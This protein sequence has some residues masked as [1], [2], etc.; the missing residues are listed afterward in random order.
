[1]LGSGLKQVCLLADYE[2]EL[3]HPMLDRLL[4]RGN[5]SRDY[6]YYGT[7]SE[8]GLLANI[9]SKG[10]KVIVPL[11]ERALQQTLGE[12]GI[13]RWRGRV[14]AHPHLPNVWVMPALQ[15]SKLMSRR[16]GDD[17][18]DALRHPPRYHGVWMR[19]L[20]KVLHI[21][22]NGFSRMP[23]NYLLDPPAERFAQFADE[24]ELALA[25]DPDLFLSWDIETP[26]KQK[27]SDEEELEEK[28]NILDGVILR[29]SFCFKPGYA[30]S[31]P[32]SPTYLPTILRLLRSRG[33][34]VVWNGSTFD[35]P[36]VQSAGYECLGL[37]F[38]F[39]DG[40]H[41]LESDLPKGLEWV[42]SEAT[43][44]LPW[45]HLAS[46]EPAHYS[47]VDADAALRN[48]LYIKAKLIE[49]GQWELFRNHVVR[50][51]PLLAAAGK[52]GNLMDLVKR[53]EIRTELTAMKLELIKEAQTYVPKQLRPRS[54]FKTQPDD[55]T[56]DFPIYPAWTEGFSVAPVLTPMG[57]RWDV[58]YDLDAGKFC[59]HCGRSVGNFAEHLKGGKK[60]N[61]CK[62][63]DAKAEKRPAYVPRFDYIEDFNPNSSPQMMSY[64]THFGHPIG[65]DKRTGKE[66]ADASH[67]KFLVKKF[68]KKFPIYALSLQLHKAIKTIG[69]YTPEPDPEGFLHTQY[70]NSTSTWRFGARK[71]KYGTQ[72]QNWGKRD[73][74]KYA[75]AARKQIIA[76]PGHKLVQ[77]DS[78]AVEAVMQ[79]YF[80]ND[81]LY[82]S[83]ASKSI[84]AWL[85]CRALGW[86]F[87]PDN[88]EKVKAEHEGLYLKMKVTNYLTNFGGGDYLL[89]QTFPENFP[90]R[91]DAV[92]A[93]DSLYALLPTLKAYHH[94][95]RWEA[96]TKTFLTTP[97]GYRH[98]YYD[99]FKPNADGTLGFGKDAKRCV[100]LKPQNSNGG[101]QKDNLL[102]L[103]ASPIDGEVL[104]DIH[105]V[106]SHWDELEKEIAAGNTWARFMP[107]NVSVHDSACLDTPDS[108]VEQAAQAQLAI[109]TRPIPQMHGLRIGAE[110]EVGA[111]WGSM[112]R[113]HK[114]VIDNYTHEHTEAGVQLIAA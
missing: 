108:L 85:A 66:T 23:V 52:R 41:L 102:L 44:I 5:L 95:V 109:F 21:A 103:G 80:M 91:E 49:R 78:S 30:V 24:Y 28:E 82:M 86:D 8:A 50:L 36:V 112:D 81:P 54:I 90:R 56:G 7:A 53:E 98:S 84:H 69:T 17:D 22:A 89:W 106:T 101:F 3:R 61:P 55:I 96:H 67:L 31:V 35:V 47:A 107:T 2:F 58:R 26:Y 40:Y 76:R 45:K 48:A 9:Q 43:D 60:N 75:K 79:G 100:A 11:G 37:V 92:A 70:V 110:V 16:G 72:I 62:A 34:S 10:I 29:I 104:T 4:R 38:D 88:V 32:W 14:V 83:L 77:I 64:M 15:P 94:S 57:E 71:V 97:W 20:Q 74:N 25:L 19:D 59:T 73:E 87:T 65:K 68:G 18:P 13:E 42:S 113:I 51:M 63:A 46:V 39:M 114:L 105:Y 33:I 27:E 6:F 111:N 1:M 12:S 93:Q 99:V